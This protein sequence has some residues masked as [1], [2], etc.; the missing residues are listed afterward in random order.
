M[1]W[2]GVGRWEVCGSEGG[3][4][5][6]AD[7]EF[8]GSYMETPKPF[9]IYRM[10]GSANNYKKKYSGNMHELYSLPFPLFH[11]FENYVST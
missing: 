3:Y 7:T 11:I 6:E 8:W 2:S 1:G 10:D 5:I 9:F 4:N